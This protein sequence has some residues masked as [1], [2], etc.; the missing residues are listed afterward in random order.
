MDGSKETS[1]SLLLFILYFLI[2]DFIV[3]GELFVTHYVSFL[4][5]HRSYYTL[6]LESTCAIAGALKH[7][8]P[9]IMDLKD[10]LK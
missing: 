2:N 10:T 4:R 6:S 1:I 3:S 5:K 8:S 9:H 7:L